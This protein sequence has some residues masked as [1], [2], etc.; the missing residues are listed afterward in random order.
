MGSRNNL[1]IDNLGYQYFPYTTI[2]SAGTTERRVRVSLPHS[3]N[4]KLTVAR[5]QFHRFAIYDI[6]YLERIE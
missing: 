6:K 3:E 2:L 4:T 5:Q 1:S